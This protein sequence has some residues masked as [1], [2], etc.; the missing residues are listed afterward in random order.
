MLY[1]SENARDRVDPTFVG[2]ISVE[3]PWDFVDREQ[4]FKPNTLAW[5]SGTG[6]S[7]LFYGLEQ[8]AKLLTETGLE[9]IQNYLDDLSNYL[10]ELLAG[11]DYEIV[12]SRARGRAVADRLHPTSEWFGV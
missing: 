6:C 10:C 7:S 3:T 12:S 5:E 11:K 2:W 9:K 1:V 8:S 4:P